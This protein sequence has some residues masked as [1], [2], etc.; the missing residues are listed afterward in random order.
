MTTYTILRYPSHH[1]A[2]ASIQLSVP[3]VFNASAR[4]SMD[5]WEVLNSLF[6]SGG[7]NYVFIDEVPKRLI[8]Q[9]CRKP[10]RDPRLV[11]CCGK[12]YCQWVVPER[13]VQEDN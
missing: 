6:G 5:V 7:Y 13:M 1:Y 10:F 12:H 3:R 2:C 11:V 8:C 9:I 4:E